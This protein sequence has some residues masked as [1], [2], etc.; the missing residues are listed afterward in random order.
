MYKKILVPLDSSKHSNAAIEL[1]LKLAKSF[2]SSVT[3]SHV[4]AA[5]LH[6]DRFRQMES[7]LP[8]KYQEEKELE[9]QRDIHDDLIT[10]GL[11]II[12]DSYSEHFAAKATEAGIDFS[13]KSLEGKWKK[14]REA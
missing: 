11:E 5:K 2:G 1:G 10:K 13:N 12:S 6:D 4:Y 14:N 3:G 9:R 8:P 7:G